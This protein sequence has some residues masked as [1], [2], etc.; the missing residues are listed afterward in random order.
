M[1]QYN[2]HS[3]IFDF[4]CIPDNV[5][6][7]TVGKLKDSWLDD[8]GNLDNSWL[9]K[10]LPKLIFFNK[11]LKAD[12]ERYLAFLQISKIGNQAQICDYLFGLYQ[13]NGFNDIRFIVLSMDM[14][15]MEAGKADT[16]Y[17]TQLYELGMLKKRYKNAFHPFVSIHPDRFNTGEDARDF[18]VRYIEVEGFAGIKLYP[19]LGFYPHSKKLYPLYEYAANK[20][21]P[22]MTHCAQGPICYRGDLQR[23]IDSPEAPAGITKKK[24]SEFQTYFTNPENYKQVLE[25]FNDLKICMAHLGGADKIR[26]GHPWFNTILDFIDN[27]KYPNVYTDISHSLHDEDTH[28]IL[29]NQVLNEKRQKHILF[30]TDFYVTTPNKTEEKLMKEFKQTLEKS[31]QNGFDIIANKNAEEY[32]KTKL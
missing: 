15:Y 19:A 10:G 13:K 29:V 6:G 11:K 1:P 27:S 12:I 25:D 16:N 3:H 24:N 7:K 32:L 4:S 21:I 26:S 30:G 31:M 5:F 2:C 14:D 23:F 22:I 20:Q 18:A 17:E 28:T 8:T 9:V